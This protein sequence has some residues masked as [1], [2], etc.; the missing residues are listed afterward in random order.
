MHRWIAVWIPILSLSIAPGCPTSPADDDDTCA[1]VCD[2]GET[3]SCLCGSDEHGA[4]TC[5]D[6]GCSW[7]SCECDSGDDDTG[8]DDTGDDDTGDDDTGDDDTGDD[9]TGDDDTGDDDTGDDDTGDDDTGDDDTGDDDTGD[10]DTTAIDADGDGWDE[11][12]DCDDGDN[13]VYP[14][15]PALCD[16]VADNDCD[17][18]DDGNETDMD[19]DGLSVCDGDCDDGSAAIYP[20]AAEVC[21]GLDNDCDLALPA[22]EADGDGDG[23]RVCDGDCDD[24]DGAV[25][26]GAAELCDGIDNDCDVA[27]PGDE[28]DDD[29]DGHMVCAGD[30]DDDR[31]DVHPGATELCDGIDNDCDLVANAPD[32]E[33]LDGDEVLACAGDC[34][35]TDPTRFPGNAEECDG[36]DNDCD[37]VLPASEEDADGDGAMVCELDCD[38]AN[39][40]VYRGAPELCDGID[41]DCDY[42]L[43][44][45]ESDD[46]GDGQAECFGDCDDGDPGTFLG[47][48][49]DCASVGDEDC[50]GSEDCADGD[51]AQAPVCCVDDP[52]EPNED[53]GGAWEVPVPSSFVGSLCGSG[54]EHDYYLVAELPYQS[55]VIYEVCAT[56]GDVDV[57]WIRIDE[58][59]YESLE[60]SSSVAEGTC[61]QVAGHTAWWATGSVL[62][63]SGSDVTS[64]TVEI[65]TPAEDP[66]TECFNGQDNDGDG[67][68]GCDDMDCADVDRDQRD[69]ET[70]DADPSS[71][72]CDDEDPDIGAQTDPWREDEPTECH[73]GKDNDCDGLRDCFDSQCANYD[74]EC[75]EVGCRP[76]DQEAS[77]PNDDAFT[78]QLITLGEVA[79]GAVCSQT[80]DVDWYRIDGIPEGWEVRCSFDWPYDIGGLLAT[81]WT[82][83]PNEIGGI[84]G[85]VFQV[86]DHYPPI[87]TDV[88]V[89]AGD[90]GDW[91]IKV[92]TINDDDD[93]STTYSFSCVQIGG[94]A[95]ET[96]CQD[97][98][99]Q[100]LDG[101]VDCDDP[102]CV[103]SIYCPC[104][105][106]GTIGCNA[107]LSIDVGTG[108]DAYTQYPC[109][110]EG[111]LGTE[112][113]LSF[114][115]PTTGTYSFS[116]TV[117][118]YGGPSDDL[119]MHVLDAE[120]ACQFGT[121]LGYGN[122]DHN[123]PVTDNVYLTAG[124]E[125][126]V[127]LDGKEGVSD[128]I[129]ALVLVGCPGGCPDA[130]FD[131]Y[132]DEACGG[133]D[134]DDGDFNIHPGIVEHCDYEDENCD[135]YD[136]PWE[137]QWRDWDGDGEGNPDVMLDLTCGQVSGYVFN[138]SD[139][140]DYDPAQNTDATEVC[141]NHED[142]DCD[143]QVDEGCLPATETDCDDGVDDDGDGDEDCDD[144]DCANDPVCA[145]VEDCNNGV[146]DDGDGDEDCDDAD[147]AAEPYCQTCEVGECC[148]EDSLVFELPQDSYNGALVANFD[149]WDG[150]RG[151]G[152]YYDDVEFEGGA[153]EEIVLEISSADFDRILYLL[154]EDCT[155]VAADN[156]GGPGEESRIEYT[157]PS[158]GVYT[159][160][161]T[162]QMPGET[163]D[164][165]LELNPSPPGAETNCSDNL[166]EDQDGLYDCD[167]PDCAYDPACVPEEVCGNG[168][169]DD[170]DGYIDCYDADCTYEAACLYATEAC[171]NGIDD[172]WDYLADCDDPDCV[173]DAACLPDA[174]V[175]D[176]NHDDD[177]DGAEDCDDPDCA[178]HVACAPPETCD[179]GADDDLD[180]YEDCDD[181]DCVNDPACLPTVETCTNGIDDD[182]DGFT[183]CVDSDCWG[184]PHCS[185]DDGD[186]LSDDLEFYLADRFRPILRF[187]SDETCQ[188]RITYWGV[189][190][191]LYQDDISIFYAFGYYDDC[192]AFLGLF[193]HRGDTEFAVV[194]ANATQANDWEMS[195]VFLSAHYKTA[196]DAS[197]W[198]YTQPPL[199]PLISVDG[200][201]PILYVAAAKHGSFATAGDDAPDYH[202]GVGDEEEVNVIASRNLGRWENYQTALLGRSEWFWYGAKRFCGWDESSLDSSDRSDCAGAPIYGIPNAGSLANSYY[203]QLLDWERGAIADG[204]DVDAFVDKE[205]DCT[206]GSDN[207]ND[208]YADCSDCDCLG[209]QDPWGQVNCPVV[210][211]EPTSIEAGDYTISPGD[212]IDVEWQVHNNGLHTAFSHTY[213]LVLSDDDVITDSDEYLGYGIVLTDVDG[214]MT[215]TFNDTVL[216][217]WIA[218]GQYYLGVILDYNHI[219]EE[220]CEYNN[221]GHATTLV[222]VY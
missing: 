2:P 126:F 66:Y 75:I 141:G 28:V 45:D 33:D 168:F 159:A 61:E 1:Q 139:C 140:D 42:A 161:V 129:D 172:D 35:D 217:P 207:D 149:E 16:G 6:D 60:D 78:A 12:E 123:S 164:Y 89:Y 85:F 97:G 39:P 144:A 137:L 110:L 171:N 106:T 58:G 87:T 167:D 107:A 49:E 156:D 10:D 77:E 150:P 29:G 56:G 124:Q 173:A 74:P 81:A 46:D 95:V 166:D 134:C 22:D 20:G 205:E 101:D 65:S 51:C 188:A 128:L 3:Q 57:E 195:K 215:V 211:V 160:I 219:L 53:E 194:N 163:G 185:D 25:F 13:A 132:P 176:N 157:L 48:T 80:D 178:A 143:N 201:Q 208:G 220:T 214:T 15:A 91:V 30:C 155:V 79:E 40:A 37:Q 200:D 122:A 44:S 184:D 99:D 41:N 17:G 218:P 67:L 165:V 170:G 63:V 146:D 86:W 82:F 213:W 21:D 221:T 186:G 169:D 125:V 108:T 115:A 209:V 96:D 199:T 212:A 202:D 23:V 59:V 64:Y 98:V 181:P 189:Q 117:A 14:G 206:D 43:P 113:I 104:V 50:D 210:D 112:Q 55:Y 5:V 32:E 119:D 68:V 177:G 147:C 105:P 24:T 72:D 93:D 204:G 52:Y 145:T 158:T 180:G 198:H 26:P 90:A 76:E 73:D 196:S 197:Y 18:L 120:T 19:G 183:D 88:D 174:E 152:Y 102:E 103:G 192:G 193:G 34:D 4:Q 182:G 31:A 114:T 190:P 83:D 111:Y 153:G 216:C 100:D 131:G 187:D 94:V 127:A 148:Y 7:S 154:D 142:D 71:M 116:T 121:C 118:A 130:D 179:N 135:P 191:N 175:C 36:V 138:D 8:D 69:N 151:L 70:C 162:T 133:T 203:C 54:E 222:T 136:E 47:G 92:Q 27:V 9:D 62:H 11:D 109:T 84:S 38:D